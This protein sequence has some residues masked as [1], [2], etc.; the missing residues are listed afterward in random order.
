[1]SVMR[2]FVFI[3]SLLAALECTAELETWNVVVVANRNDPE[4]VHLGKYYL[5]KREI[6]PEN[7][8]LLSA[9]TAETISW[10][11]FIR[12]IFNPL[13]AQLVE[14]GWIDAI[15]S[16]LTDSLDRRRY[17][18]SGHKIGYLVLCRGMPLRI[19]NY[20]DFLDEKAL[21]NI[22]KE[23]HTN[24]GSVDAELALLALPD[25]P[26]AGFVGNFLFKNDKPAFEQ[27]QSVVKVARLDGPS[28]NDAQG[29]I[30]HAL[31]VEKHGLMGRAY[32]DENG[33]HPLGNRWLRA[34]SAEIEALGYDL[35]VE[36]TD[37]AFS[38]ASRFDAPALYFGWYHDHVNGPFLNPEFRF[39]TGAIAVHIH[40]FSAATLRDPQKHWCGPLVAR[41]AAATLGNVFEPFLHFSHHLDAFFHALARGEN[42]GDAAYFALPALSWQAV[43]IGDPLYRPFQVPIQEQIYS[44]SPDTLAYRQYAHIRQM[45]LLLRQGDSRAALTAG[46]NGFRSSPGLAL[47]WEIAQLYDSHGQI[48]KA[49]RNLLFV[50]HRPRFE[51]DEWQVAK[52]AADYL[53]QADQ[54]RAALAIYKMLIETKRLPEVILIPLLEDGRKIAEETGK[55]SLART[56]AA[57]RRALG[58]SP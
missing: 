37:Q 51:H 40:S 42:L 48:E 33:R 53:N 32:I 21:Q 25:Y 39:A 10:P 1:M 23:L 50:Q 55:L 14:R 4:S 24:R 46:R 38:R 26:I 9:P 57:H 20:P 35:Q 41:G 13:L 54:R 56:W 15:S 30:D 6:P 18:V 7:L 22:P 45:R 31:L 3:I 36:N 44:T 58:I 28:L 52:Q 43:L 47:G 5:E 19:E 29:L 49:A 11:T 8:L 34:I 17:A 27:E 12:E 16:D 2:I